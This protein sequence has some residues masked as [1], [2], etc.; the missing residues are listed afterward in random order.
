MVLSYQM[1]LA[2]VAVLRLATYNYQLASD[3][4]VVIS[5]LNYT[6]HVLVLIV[7]VF[8]FIEI[9]TSIYVHLSVGL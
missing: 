6:I 3:R 9:Y 7:V 8:H 4:R 1:L 2:A 5:I